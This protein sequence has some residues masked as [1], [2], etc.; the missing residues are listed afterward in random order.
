MP[1][2]VIRPAMQDRLQLQR[3]YDDLHV[4]DVVDVVAHDG[5]PANPDGAADDAAAEFATSHESHVFS[6]SPLVAPAAT[7][8]CPWL[9]P[10]PASSRSR[11][12]V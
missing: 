1:Q 2:Q 7:G 12:C 8:E 5:L 9:Q 6:V 4:C 11:L 3:D 10:A